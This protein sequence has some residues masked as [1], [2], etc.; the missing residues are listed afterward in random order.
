MGLAEVV[1]FPATPEGRVALQPLL[2]E[3][4]RRGILSLLVEG[5]GTVHSSF[6]TEG[7]VDKVYAY[8]APTLI[9]GRD[10][11]TALGGLGVEHLA[12]AVRL[13]A[14]DS[15]RLGDD[16]LITGYVDVHRD[17]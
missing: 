13:R 2:E 7:L 8:V 11:P 10:A 9:G 14:L 16:L 15:T 6:V 4:G 17:S 5:G 1:K 3:L 12:Q